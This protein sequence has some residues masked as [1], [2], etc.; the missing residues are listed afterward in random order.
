MRLKMASVMLALVPATALAVG[1]DKAMFVGGTVSGIQPK[2]EGR[3]DTTNPDALVFRSSKGASLEIPWAT[4]ESIEYGQKASRRIRSA[5]LLSPLAL[6][7]K[8]RKHMVSIAYKDATGADQ[9]VVFEFGK[10]VYRT[11]LAALKAKT[12]KS[13]AC[14]D[15]DAQKQMGGS[16]TVMAPEPEDEK[17]K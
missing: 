12:G 15:E 11:N 10:D 14:Q 13:V 4:V 17:K 7:H 9:A 5:I 6:F 2:T 8:A 3:T 1:S 16:C